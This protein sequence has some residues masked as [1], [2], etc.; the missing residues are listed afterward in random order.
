MIQIE[1]DFRV[2]KAVDKPQSSDLSYM[3]GIAA[4]SKDFSDFSRSYIKRFTGFPARET[5]L[6]DIVQ[7]AIIEGFDVRA[8]CFDDGDYLDIGTVDDL[9]IAIRRSFID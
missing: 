1:P 7:Q 9:L 2:V 5:L 3:W 6:G 4:W 8:V